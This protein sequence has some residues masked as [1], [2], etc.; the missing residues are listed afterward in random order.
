MNRRELLTG[1]AALAVA[2]AL[3]EAA[4]A[5]DAIDPVMRPFVG[6]DPGVGPG[7]IVWTVIGVTQKGERVLLDSWRQPVDQALVIPSAITGTV[8]V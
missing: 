7:C 2:A 5:Y 1:A 3:P 4:V 6:V 8:T